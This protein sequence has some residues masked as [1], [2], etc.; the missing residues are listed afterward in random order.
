LTLELACGGDLGYLRHT[1]AM[2]ASVLAH[3]GSLA[4]RVHYLHDPALSPEDA[5]RLE[6][7]VRGQGAELQLHPIPAER[8]EGLV[9]I[10]HLTPA[11]WYRVFLPELLP[12]AERVLYLDADVIAVDGLEPLWATELGDATVAAV[13]N[14]FDPWNAGYEDALQLAR[15]YFNSGVLLM[16]LARMRATDATARVLDYARANP[17]R[18]PWGDQDPLN[19]VLGADRLELHPRWNCM[20][21]FFAY[22]EA[23]AEIFGPV[24]AAD[25]R[26][27]PGIR[28]FEGPSINKPWHLLCPHPGGR[29]Y[30]RQR[31][32][33]PWPRVERDGV[34]PANVARRLAR[35]ARPLYAPIVRRLRA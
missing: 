24:E 11:M 15:P 16:N 8:I 32:R 9:G 23:T 29:E 25:A 31:R 17:E 5:D 22:P 28:H 35:P 2:I 27:R 1:A 4:A 7:M 20:N 10:N 30:F 14:V 33:T 12:D 19:I 21:S 3:R 6:R 18:L 13:T 34:T 26:E